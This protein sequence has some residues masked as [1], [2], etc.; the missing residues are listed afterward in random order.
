MKMLTYK[1]RVVNNYNADISGKCS[2]TLHYVRISRNLNL[3]AEE[4]KLKGKKLRGRPVRRKK[5]RKVS[6]DEDDEIDFETNPGK[7]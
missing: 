5:K 2:V 3:T 1:H 4:A 7:K 6:D